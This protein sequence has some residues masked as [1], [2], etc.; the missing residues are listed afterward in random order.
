VG[1]QGTADYKGF[2]ETEPWTV[3][4]V[5]FNSG[6]TPARNVKFSN[7]FITSP[8]PL[9]GPPPEYVKDF[10]FR[11]AQSIPPQGFFRTALGPDYR[12]SGSTDKQKQGSQKLL[13][14]YGQIKNKSLFLY[15]YGI[16]KYDD[17]SGRH[18]ETEF[19]FALANI[20]TKEAFVCDSFNDL[21]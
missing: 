9:R 21:N 4:V 3:T 20:D 11:S 19:C 2:T 5:F 18:H 7:K 15:Y 8:A 6:R 13:D 10:D 17:N 16:L 1:V 14:L 12:V